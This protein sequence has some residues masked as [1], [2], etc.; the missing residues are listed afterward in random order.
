MHFKLCPYR[1]YS[2]IYLPFLLLLAANNHAKRNAEADVGMVAASITKEG[3]RLEA[4]LGRS[5]EKS[6]KANTDAL[7]AHFQEE[8]AKQEK[9]VRDR[10]HQITS[11]ITNCIN[12]DFPAM[13]EKTVKKELAA[14]GPAV[15]RTITPNI[16]RTVSVAIAEAFQVNILKIYQSL[17]LKFRTC[18]LIKNKKNLWPVWNHF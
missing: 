10:T 12:K 8:S 18:L 6:L 4:G 16:E 13:L 9:L 11:L 2:P 5:M 3:R 7:W 14:V 15:A 17:L 1:T